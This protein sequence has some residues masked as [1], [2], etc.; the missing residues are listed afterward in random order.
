MP[1]FREPAVVHSG[2]TKL[3]RV[4]HRPADRGAAP[5]PAVLVCG[6]FGGT[7]SGR[8]SNFVRVA[9]AL[10]E[11]GFVVLR[12]DYRGHGDSEGSFSEVT[13]DGE[14]EDALS[15]IEWLRK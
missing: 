1:E 10:A 12:F 3:F 2:G 8:F 15:C 5:F 11:A 4:V 7:K 6:G 9:Q 14:V 13:I